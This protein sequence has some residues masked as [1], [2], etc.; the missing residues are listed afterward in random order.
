MPGSTAVDDATWSRVERLVDAAESDVLLAPTSHAGILASLFPEDDL[1]V[2]EPRPARFRCSCSSERVRNALRIAG[3][4]EIEA[5]IAE[6]GD[7]EVTC[8]FC[9]RRYL[10]APAE[11]RAVF[12]LSPTAA[13]DSAEATRH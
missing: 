5:A 2:F 8:E 1:R 11:A 9:N 4:A 13:I 3:R 6:R 10:F 12:A 7:V